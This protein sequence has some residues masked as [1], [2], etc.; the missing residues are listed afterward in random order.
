[1]VV[2][3]WINLQYLFSTLDQQRFG[4]GKKYTHNVVGLLGAYQGNRSD[5]QVGLPYESLFSNDGTP[6]HLPQRLLVCIEA[7]PERVQRIIDKTPS[8]KRLVENGWIH[9]HVLDPLIIR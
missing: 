6:Y 9:L 5:L 3:A 4:S 2:G 8:V 1:M 7:P